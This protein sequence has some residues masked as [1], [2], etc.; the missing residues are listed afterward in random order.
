VPAL[1]S[2]APDASA[3]TLF[4]S[5]SWTPKT[6]DDHSTLSAVNH[7]YSRSVSCDHDSS[8]C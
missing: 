6:Q 3:R 4:A 1:E 2:K 7:T 8:V 5:A